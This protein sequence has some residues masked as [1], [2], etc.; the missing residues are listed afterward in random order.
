MKTQVELQYFKKVGIMHLHDI[1]ELMTTVEFKNVAKN[2]IEKYVNKDIAKTNFTWPLSVFLPIIFVS[3]ACFVPI[4]IIK[5]PFGFIFFALIPFSVFAMCCCLI[6]IQKGIQDKIAKLKDKIS[7]ETQGCLRLESKLR[8]GQINN[9]RRHNRLYSGR[10]TIVL[11]V[12]VAHQHKFA[13]KYEKMGLLEQH[14]V[15]ASQGGQ[16]NPQMMMMNNQGMANP[17]FNLNLGPAPQ[18]VV[19]PQP[20]GQQRPTR[21]NQPMPFNQPPPQNPNGGNFFDNLGN[22][23]TPQMMNMGQ[24]NMGPN[25]NPN[26]Q[27]NPNMNPNMPHNPNM[28]PMAPGLNMNPMAPG[29]HMNLMGPGPGPNRMN[30]APGPGNQGGDNQ[31]P[32]FEVDLGRK[33]PQGVYNVE[34]QNIQNYGQKK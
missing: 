27:H 25:M 22:N 20:Y 4:N 15:F 28:N 19:Q 5:F 1:D 31:I 14:R 29:P 18:L 34:D 32:T 21:P 11:R 8:F 7:S 23:K 12:M 9:R 17:V 26:M 10:N 33:D 16:Q 2:Y 30:M 3:F 13:Q 24:P 6:K